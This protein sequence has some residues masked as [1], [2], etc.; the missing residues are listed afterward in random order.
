MRQDVIDYQWGR[1]YP[2]LQQIGYTGPLK[3]FT[4][5]LRSGI[6]Q[7]KLYWA[8]DEWNITRMACVHLY[9]DDAY[10][11]TSKGEAIL[12]VWGHAGGDNKN[13][14]KEVAAKLTALGIPARATT[15]QKYHVVA[16]DAGDWMNTPE[17]AD[18]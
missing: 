11:V 1:L 3:K 5:R 9:Q 13:L 16:F 6:F 14:A 4:H 8:W 10:P 18:A 12:H 2:L 15:Y 7:Y 17:M